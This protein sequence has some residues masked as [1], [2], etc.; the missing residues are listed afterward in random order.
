MIDLL[1]PHDIEQ[2]LESA[3]LEGIKLQY[4]S[5]LGEWFIVFRDLELYRSF[6][7]TII[8]SPLYDVMEQSNSQVYPKERAEP[9]EF[10]VVTYIHHYDDWED[11]EG[12]FQSLFTLIRV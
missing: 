12:F 8:D 3:G 4:G 2:R 5:S 6:L 1:Q 7:T 9:L 11:W 10:G